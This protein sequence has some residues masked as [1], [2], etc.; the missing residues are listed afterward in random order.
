MLDFFKRKHRYNFY[1][2]I[3]LQRKISVVDSKRLILF[4]ES[5]KVRFQK[6]KIEKI[7]DNLY[8]ISICLYSENDI[9]Q[10]KKELS[11]YREM[12]P[13]WVAFPDLFHGSPRWN[14]GFEE[15]YCI[16]HWLPYWGSLDFNH[17]QEYLLRYDCPKEWNEWLEIYK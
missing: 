1:L 3:E 5:I 2:P 13:P 17:K 7:S 11:L 12:M 6:L 16:N 9:D 14:Q 8:Y 15:D 4:L 10:L